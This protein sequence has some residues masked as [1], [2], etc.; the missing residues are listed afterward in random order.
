[1]DIGADLFLQMI[2]DIYS[3]YTEAF[4]EKNREWFQKAGHNFFTEMSPKAEEGDTEEFYKPWMEYVREILA[5]GEPGLDFDMQNKILQRTIQNGNLY[6]QFM[7]TVLDAA[8]ASYADEDSDETRNEIYNKITQQYLEFY[9]E[10]VGKYFGVPQFGIQREALHQVMAAIDSHH[11]FMVAV[12][13]FLVKFNMPLKNSLKIIQQAIRDREEAGEGFKSAKE[14]YNFATKILEK[15]YDEFIKSPEG[16]QDV[17]DVVEKYVDY[18]KKS[19]IVKDIL[20]RSMSIPTRREMEDVYRGIYDLKK[21]ARQQ[22]AIIR[23]QKDLI[24]TLSRKLQTIE[25]SLSGSLQKKKTSASS[26]TQ[27]RTK[28]KAPVKA[29]QKDRSSTKDR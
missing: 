7:N 15:R 2:K 6:V 23:E 13:E 12:G 18:K 5:K 17:V 24:N 25:G 3:G 4:S 20:F 16:V 22:D 26:T 11:R 8:K 10:S 21:K 9:H 28:V 1:M 14:I 29:P 27:K 19:N